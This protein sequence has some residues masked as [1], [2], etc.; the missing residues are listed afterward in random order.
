MSVQIT[1]HQAPG[2]DL[3]NP[4]SNANLYLHD[5][6]SG[7]DLKSN[8]ELEAGENYTLY[9]EVKNEGT[10]S[11]RRTIVEFYYSENTP[12]GWSDLTAIGGATRAD[13]HAGNTVTVTSTTVFTPE[14]GKSYEFYVV[15]YSN[16]DPKPSTPEPTDRHVAGQTGIVTQVIKN[17]HL[18]L[19]DGIKD[20]KQSYGHNPNIFV[21]DQNGNISNSPEG[22]QLPIESGKEYY[23]KARVVN[24][25]T[26][27]DDVQVTFYA[28]YSGINQE[29]KDPISVSEVASVPANG[30]EYTFTSQDLWKYE[31]GENC[32]VAV[33]STISDSDKVTGTNLSASDRH[34]AQ[35]NVHVEYPKRSQHSVKK[36][37]FVPSLKSKSFSVQRISADQQNHSQFA[38]RTEAPELQDLLIDGTSFKDRLEDIKDGIHI[39]ATSFMDKMVDFELVLPT[40]KSESMCAGYK[41]TAPEGEYQIL[42][43]FANIEVSIKKTDETALKA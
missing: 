35:H 9:A 3:G 37:L 42:I 36:R 40:D 38:D 12:A 27:S 14:K 2:Y 13:I 11:E 39:D 4:M 33:C 1:L 29:L 15:A 10:S 28:H 30:G 5:N 34:M 7:Q 26:D 31:N 32:L 8:I 20:V 17:V 41:I 25:G 16:A 23:L 43:D 18:T 24:L 19:H 21:E 6:N 22:K